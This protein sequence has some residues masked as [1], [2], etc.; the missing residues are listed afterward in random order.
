[1]GRAQTGSG[2]HVYTTLAAS[3]GTQIP[4]IFTFDSLAA[5]YHTIERMVFGANLHQCRVAWLPRV[6]DCRRV[7][8]LGE[9]D[10]RF[11]AEFLPACP[12]AK[13]EVC[14]FSHGMVALTRQRVRDDP[15]VTFHVGDARTL[16]FPSGHYD[17]VVTNFFLDCFPAEQLE[18]LIRRLSDTLSPGGRWIVG[19]FRCE[20]T[21]AGRTRAACKLAVMY[22]FFRLTT[23]LP[24]KSLADPNPF[25]LANGLE[26][27]EEVTWQG[28]FLSAALWQRSV[29]VSVR[30]S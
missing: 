26:R 14:D 17:L 23:R 1:M 21:G 10:G 29:T 6:A 19:D 28:G 20:G 27:V 7:L 16:D 12:L 2:R 25:L 5:F 30:E 8:V 13:V 9:G 3:G 4:E 15:R 11:L 24:A 18:P 22:A